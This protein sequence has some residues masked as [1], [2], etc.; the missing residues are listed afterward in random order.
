MFKVLVS[1]PIAKE[2]LD[3]LSEEATVDVRLGLNKDELKAILPE[4]D[5]LIVRSETKVTSEIIECGTR[6]Q[7]IGRAGVGVDNIDLEAAT[8]K[9]IAVVNAPTGN[10]IAA[11][12]HTLALLFSL[13]RHVPQANAAMRKGEWKR[14]AFMGSEVRGK[15]LG[16]I[17]LGKVGSAVARRASSFDMQLL[18]YDPYISKEHARRLGIELT[19]L[20]A[21]YQKSDFITVHVPMTDTTKSLIGNAELSMMKEGVKLI[22]VARGGIINENALLEHL[23]S[24]KVSGAALDV[25]IKEP[26]GETD[27]IKH[28][29]VISTP[30]LGGSTTEAQTEVARE[31]A[32]EAISV[33][34]GKSAKSTVNMPFLSPDVQEVVLPYL[35]TATAL[36]KLVFQLAEGQF[37][38]LTIKYSGELAAYSTPTL[39]AAALMGFLGPVSEEKVNLVN[40]SVLA[41]QRGIRILEETD[42]EAGVYNASITVMANTDK[43]SFSLTGTQIQQETHIV[44]VN[45]YLVDVVP[46]SQYLLFIEHQDK[47]GMI[48]ALGTLTGSHDINI[49]FMAVGREAPR[50]KAMMVVGLDDNVPEPVLNEIRSITNIDRARLVKI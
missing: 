15:V 44:Q 25:F 38:S 27:L 37:S 23:N 16:I 3:I 39:K 32:Q 10:T 19:A 26:P 13:A 34:N 1:D 28:P 45:D 18:G 29:F 22:N 31:V 50:G 43:G 42:S 8:R 48:G 33:L 6:L 30:H 47:P 36:G 5:G 41:T 11:A 49:A 9:G 24:G 14:S 2:G 17:G 20:E 46:S 4:Y 35:D 12:E 7:V 21:L 40:A